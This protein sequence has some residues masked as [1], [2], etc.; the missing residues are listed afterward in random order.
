MGSQNRAGQLLLLLRTIKTES[1]HWATKF[2]K[3]KTDSILTVYIGFNYMQKEKNVIQTSVSNRQ[4]L[5][6]SRLVTSSRNHKGSY[7]EI[8]FDWPS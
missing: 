3:T 2:H 6:E 7:F 5:K 1:T 8:L 4:T